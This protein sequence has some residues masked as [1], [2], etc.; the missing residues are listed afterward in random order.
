MSETREKRNIH[1]SRHAS[2]A[3]VAAAITNAGAA[4]AV[5]VAAG[6]VA[7]RC[8]GGQSGRCRWW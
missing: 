5:A 6:A 8:R 7:C 1:G 4:G 2:R 3:P